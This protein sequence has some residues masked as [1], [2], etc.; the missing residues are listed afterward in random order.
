MLMPLAFAALNETE[1]VALP[2]TTPLL[3][4]RRRDQTIDR[5]FREWFAECRHAVL[6]ILFP[7]PVHASPLPGSLTHLAERCREVEYDA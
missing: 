6:P 2:S 1:A 4:P 5:R 7:T 3:R